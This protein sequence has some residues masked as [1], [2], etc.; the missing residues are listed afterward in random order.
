[1]KHFIS[2]FCVATLLAW[3]TLQVHA[4]LITGS[5]SGTF[6]IP[7][8]TPNVGAASGIY[9]DSSQVSGIANPYVASLSLTFTIVGGWAGDYTLVLKHVSADGL[10]S[11]SS[12]LF[13]SLLG[14]AA[15]SSG[16]SSVTLSSATGAD[17][18][19]PN[20]SSTAALT[21]TMYGVNF[22]PFQ[23]VAPTGDWILYAT[24]NAGGG[25]GLLGG[26][27]LNLEVVPEPTNL[28]L[29]V[30]GGA[31][32]LAA[33]RKKLKSE[34]FKS[35]CPEYRCQLGLPRVEHGKINFFH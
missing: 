28:A 13:S 1:M 31:L 11:Q 7:D 6:A 9:I 4:A 22:S 20:T 26:W 16:F 15:A 25:N 21:G 12:T 3:S 5:N 35:A 18:A 27:S 19:I 10:T 23:N 32:G 29:G 33:L 24:D 14:G 2:T 34:N 30:F 8:N 17:T